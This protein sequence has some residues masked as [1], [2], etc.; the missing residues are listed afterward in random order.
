MNIIQ[1]STNIQF[2]I[3]ERKRFFEHKVV[4]TEFIIRYH[5]KLRRIIIREISSGQFCTTTQCH[6]IIDIASQPYYT[7]NPRDPVKDF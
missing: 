4:T 2:F 5:A 7:A 3:K 6:A 1:T